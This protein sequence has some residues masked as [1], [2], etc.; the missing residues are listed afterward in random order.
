V[1]YCITLDTDTRLPRDAAKEL[2]G[3]I[4]HPL[5]RRIRCPRR[6]C[7]RAATGSAARQV[8]GQRGRV[9]FARPTPNIPASTRIQPPV[10]T[11][12]DPF[13]EGI[14]TARL[15][16]VDAFVASP[17]DACPER[18]TSHNLSKGSARGRR[19]SPTSKSS[20][21]P[22]ASSHTRDAGIVSM[23]DWQIC[24]GSFRSSRPAPV[25]SAPPFRSCRAEDPRQ[26]RRSLMALATVARPPGLDWSCRAVV[27]MDGRSRSLPSPAGRPATAWSSSAGRHRSNRMGVPAR[28]ATN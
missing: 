27:G 12:T 16:D 14:F 22:S 26:F 24:G 7:G 18:P 15:Y 21:I 6:P 20:T 23:G 8:D 3:I 25:Y 10:L 9:S 11:S 13:D 2:I 5:N 4:A 28:R 17:R 1:R 19:S